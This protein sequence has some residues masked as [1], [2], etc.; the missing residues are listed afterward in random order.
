MRR[1]D[2]RDP[3]TV[4]DVDFRITLRL[5]SFVR[6]HLRLVALGFM[7]MFLA[8]AFNLLQPYII[9]VVI[10]ENLVKGN[11]DGF[12]LSVGFF[13]LAVLG[14]TCFTYLQMVIVTI[15][16]QRVILDIR[17]RL[18]GKVMELPLVYFDS[19]PTGRVVTRHVS[20]VEAVNEMIS[21]GLVSVIGDI[22]L[23]FSVAVILLFMDRSLFLFTL[24]SIGLLVLFVHVMKTRLRKANR[25][26]RERTAKMNAFLQEYISGIGVIK[27]FAREGKI[28]RKFQGHNDEFKGVAVNLSTLYS[29]YFPGVE[30]ISALAVAVV[31]WRGGLGVMAGSITIGTVIAF[32]GYLEKFF[33]PVKDMSDKYNILQSALASCE[34]IFTILDMESS[35]DYLPS[36][37]AELSVRK[38]RHLKKAKGPLIMFKE[39]GFNYGG[40]EVLDTFSLSIREGERVA[41]VGPTGAGKTTIVNLLL[42][43]YRLQSGEITYDGRDI[44]SYDMRELRRRIVLIPQDPF[45]F[46]GTVLDNILAGEGYDD[47]KVDDAL[48]SCGIVEL[49]DRFADGL[50]TPVGERG[51]RLS[52]GQRQLV[53]FAR[54]VY[55]NPHV[56]VLDEAT[57]NI[58]PATEQDVTEALGRMM[59]GKTSIVIAHRLQ[60]V[61][62]CD[63]IAV[64][65]KGKL[66]EEGAHEELMRAGGLYSA[67]YNLQITS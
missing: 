60:T 37:R 66:A 27:S 48:K 13:T 46:N 32:A 9:K 31:L 2:V 36:R 42:G 11:L 8:M 41:I 20:D 39:V 67:L 28:R 1:V 58:D 12:F 61:V 19:T 5:L 54:A 16:G 3:V 51:S 21:S 65:S 50:N 38:A 34:R 23:I 33:G 4:K 17:N 22:V 15:L 57:A 40:E 14:R 44:W 56:L 49:V 18:F 10:D 45:L 6:P 25:A 62:E 64:V 47:K 30:V 35:P 63:K 7:A 29:V 24:L 52:A 26:L 43:F 53:S 55:R 59:E